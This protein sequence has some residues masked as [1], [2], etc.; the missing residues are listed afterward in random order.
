MLLLHVLLFFLNQE[1]SLGISEITKKRQ[2]RQTTNPRD[3]QPPPQNRTTLEQKRTL[4]LIIIIFNAQWY[5]IPRGL[6]ISKV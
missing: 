4:T 2:A 5:F 1:V 6:E 3:Q